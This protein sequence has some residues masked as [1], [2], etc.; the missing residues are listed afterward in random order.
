MLH[1]LCQGSDW[2]PLRGGVPLLRRADGT[3]LDVPD[4]AVNLVPV[5]VNEAAYAEK[6]IALSLT[7][8]EV[9]PVLP[10][11]IAALEKLLGG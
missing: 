3:V 10:N 6:R 9:W 5:F 4:D 2:R 8:R 11:W 7:Q 1:S